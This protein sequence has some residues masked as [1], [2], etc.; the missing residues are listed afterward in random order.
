MDDLSTFNKSFALFDAEYRLL[1]WNDDFVQE[2]ADAT[3]IIALG[4]KVKDIYAAC[5]LPE[6]AL[7]LS[8]TAHGEVPPV[9][10]Y[11]NNR[12]TISVEQDV[13]VGG[14]ILRIA[15]GACPAAALHP[16][17]AE[18]STELLRSAALQM[19]ASVLKQRDQEA[20]RLN[21]LARKDQQTGVG[22]RLYFDEQLMKDWQQCQSA[23]QPLSMLY[24]TVDYFNSYMDFYGNTQGDSCLKMVAATIRAYLNVPRDSIARYGAEEF[25]CLM[26]KTDLA[27]AKI[28][29]EAL[30]SAIRALAIPH[31]KSK[32]SSIVTISV[33]VASTEQTHG[34]SA[35]ALVV[36]AE[37]QV[38]LA[39]R[40]GRDCIRSANLY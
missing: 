33:G 30:L 38:Y 37:Q 34:D 18:N 20:S 40:D 35:E 28:M 17:M 19:S 26:P 16:S 4:V 9:F 13:G 5:L 1:D 10:E 39:K 15:K 27:S 23:Q 6:R 32:A 12:L 7:D 8:W 29:A 14:T 25:A 21:E 36:A 3:D 2:F 11:I 24:V 31:A 22:N